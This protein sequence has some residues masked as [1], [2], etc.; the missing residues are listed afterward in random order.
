M[1]LNGAI[2]S[3]DLIFT[4]AKFVYLCFGQKK[5]QTWNIPLTLPIESLSAMEASTIKRYNH[6][7]MHL[8]WSHQVRSK[9]L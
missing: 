3:S 1:L 7:G 4:E 6:T 9:Q 5:Q 8:V 2:Y